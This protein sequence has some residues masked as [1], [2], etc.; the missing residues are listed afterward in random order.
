MAQ[1][2]GGTVEGYHQRVS[3]T[4]TA[5][6]KKTKSYSTQ[7]SQVVPHLSTNYANTSLTSE[8]GRDPVLP[9]VY[10]HNWNYIVETRLGTVHVM[11]TVNKSSRSMNKVNL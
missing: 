4:T 1:K 3:S 2:D 9:G 6:K 8:I 10:G 11:V 5:S 7:Y